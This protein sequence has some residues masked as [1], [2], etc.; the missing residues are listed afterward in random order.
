M[1]RRPNR[2]SRVPW[3]PRIRDS[4]GGG[5][6][7]ARR[8]DATA[9]SPHHLLHVRLYVSVRIILCAFSQAVGR[10]MLSAAPLFP[11]EAELRIHL[12]EHGDV[13]VKTNA[14]RDDAS[15][16]GNDVTV[17]AFIT[18]MVEHSLRKDA[19]LFSRQIS[20][21]DHHLGMDGQ[22]LEVWSVAVLQGLHQLGEVQLLVDPD[23]Q[24]V[25]VNEIPQLPGGELEPGGVP[26]GPVERFD[27]RPPRL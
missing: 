27:H 9:L 8:P 17:G 26:A 5:R 23:Q 14:P 22:L 24:V 25:R 11:L 4:C 18:E 2:R 13:K 6:R 1:A 20:A 16:C 15:L 7:W 12:A 21:P 3:V 10:E 19:M